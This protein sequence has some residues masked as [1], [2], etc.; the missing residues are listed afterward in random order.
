[1]QVH[2]RGERLLV[3]RG[4]E[5]LQDIPLIKVARV[6]LMGRGV[7]ITTPT[8]YALARRQ[9][10]VLFLNSRG[11]Y[12]LRMVGREHKHSRLRQAQALAVANPEQGLGIARAIVAGKVTNQRVLVQRHARGEAGRPEAWAGKA[13]EQMDAMR[14]QVDAAHTLDELR[15]REGL[16]AREYFGLLRRL[17]RPPAGAA[18]W[19]FERRE[20]YPPPDPINALL[21]FGYTLLL[22]DLI[23][24]CQMA[25]LDP[26]LGFLHAVDYGK[27]AMALD[28]EE[29]FRPVIVD[30]IVL[31]AANRPLFSLAD[32]EVGRPQAGEG[33]DA[34]E[35][36]AAR[37]AESGE[38]RPPRHP[39]YLK[40]AARKRFI[41]LYETRINETVIYPPSGEQTSYRR[42]FE[43]QAYR[44]AQAILGEVDG[45]LP[46]TVR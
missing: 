22:N 4:D 24:A 28:L 16:A 36:A 2:K 18:T 41:G 40:E 21:S 39:I 31:L 30:S 9:V 44:M 42:V 45:Y 17:L 37:E 29:E 32:F 8:L 43:L 27:P 25:G 19:G 7:N 34:D 14:R 46:F 23:A 6:V 38:A 1:M 3:Q 20:Y 11:G 5:L 12:M 26:D 35:P 33:E 13:L 15:G 10:D